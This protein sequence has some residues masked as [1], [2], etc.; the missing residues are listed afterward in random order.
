MKLFDIAVLYLSDIDFTG[1]DIYTPP[2][3]SHLAFPTAEHIGEIVI[4][5]ERVNPDIPLWQKQS[6][7]AWVKFN[8]DYA[9]FNNEYYRSVVFSAAQYHIMAI[10]NDV[11]SSWEAAYWIA[12]ENRSI[13]PMFFRK[14]WKG[15]VYPEDVMLKWGEYCKNLKDKPFWIDYGTGDETHYEVFMMNAYEYVNSKNA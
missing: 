13:I 5:E 10:S 1:I 4:H 2:A 6:L 8:R 12:L 11:P 3:P 7:E 14:K 9:H 15:T